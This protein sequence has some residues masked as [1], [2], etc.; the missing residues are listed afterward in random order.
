M[1]KIPEN[2]YALFKLLYQYNCLFIAKIFK[3]D[4][5]MH[6]ELFINLN[7]RKIFYEK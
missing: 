5:E 7:V 6:K 4:L 3:I 2:M 1:F